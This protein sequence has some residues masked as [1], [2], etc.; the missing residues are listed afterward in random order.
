MANDRGQRKPRLGPADPGRGSLWTGQ[1]QRADHGV[2]GRKTNDQL[3]ESAN[4]LPCRPSGRWKNVTGQKRGQS[5]GPQ[6]CEDVA[7]RRARRS[8]NPRPSPHVF[9]RLA[10]PD[11]PGD[12]EGWRHQSGVPHR[13]DRQDGVRLQRRSIER[14]ARSA[15]SGAKQH[16]LRPL[17]RG[18]IRFVESAV[19]RDS[20]L[21]GKHPARFAGPTG[22]HSAKFL[23]RY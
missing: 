13:R 5:A 18:T 22:N 19:Y 12:E 23:Y 15:G 7:W 3:A 4:H 9:G 6:I 1:S 21:F 17:H 10:W 8:G 20:Q 14:D 2:F 16:V 11:H